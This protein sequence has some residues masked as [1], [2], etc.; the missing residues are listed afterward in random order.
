M[1]NVAFTLVIARLEMDGRNIRIVKGARREEPAI[2]EFR[3]PSET[4]NK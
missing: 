2:D 3:Q 4:E 1:A